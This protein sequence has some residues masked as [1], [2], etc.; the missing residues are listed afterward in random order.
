MLNG[1]PEGT[2]VVSCGHHPLLPAGSR[3]TT[4]ADQL[5]RA[6]RQGGVRVYLCGHDHGF[7]AVLEEDLQQITVG[8]PHASP[9]WA[10]RLTID[11][12]GMRWRVVDLYAA[13]DP[14][15]LRMVERTR[16]L[17]ETIARGALENTPYASDEGAIAW[18]AECFDLAVSC[19]LTEASCAALLSNPN[20]QKWLEAQT[21]TVAKQWMF[22]L[23]EH[24]P[25]D[26]REI[27]I[28]RD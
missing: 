6:L 14:Q 16:Q 25:Q 12:S 18:F 10:G 7:A 21:R 17:G 19:S 15:W 28:P 11:D 4:N 27:R 8:Q 5:A 24:C 3:Q 26:P 9:G 2:P 1:L 20:A 22:D 13:D 23:L